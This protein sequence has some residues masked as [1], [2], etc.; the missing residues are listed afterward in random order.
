MN[1][2]IIK[3]RLTADPI[4]KIANDKK[5]CSFCVAVNRKFAKDKTDFIN[6]EAWG[7]SAE[8]LEKYFKKGKEILVI[9]ELHIDVVKSGEETKSYTKI[10]VDDVEFCGSKS[11]SAAP[12]KTDAEFSE[13][14]G[15]EELPF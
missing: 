3:G 5:V 1:K 12:Q 10:S 13:V 8:F 11:E 4:V 9:G 2:I 15:S 7:K 6:C 14:S